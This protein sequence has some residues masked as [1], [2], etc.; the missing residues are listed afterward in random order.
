MSLL[1]RHVGNRKGSG[2]SSLPHGC[3]VATPDPDVP[4]PSSRH[5]I[6][7]HSEMARMDQRPWWRV[8]V[9][10][11][12]GGALWMKEMGLRKKKTPQCCIYCAVNREYS[13]F[14][15]LDQG[16]IFSLQIN[17][18]QIYPLYP[19]NVLHITSGESQIL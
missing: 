3:G 7:D 10:N 5:R 8:L 11:R 4:F 19:K 16:Q 6:G 2:G 9:G 18:C 1:P 17:Q 13:L 14:I 12:L 15:A